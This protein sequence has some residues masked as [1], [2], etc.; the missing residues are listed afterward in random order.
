M[1]FE[2]TWT[3]NWEGA[4]RGLRHPMESY[5]KADTCWYADTPTWEH[6]CGN[7]ALE[8]NSQDATFLGIGQNDMDLAQR[9]IKA[10]SPNDKFLR[11]IFVSVDITGPLYWWKEMDTYKV[12]TTANSTTTMHKLA[13]TPIT[14]EYCHYEGPDAWAPCEQDEYYA[15]LA[16]EEAEVRA[17]AEAAAEEYEIWLMEQAI[18]DEDY[19]SSVEYYGEPYDYQEF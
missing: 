3:G 11:Q 15:S 16:A 5:D 7:Q 18:A 17:E 4:F 13:S 8:I 19:R 9:M 14:R 10:G 12:A 1:K 2:N 6:Y